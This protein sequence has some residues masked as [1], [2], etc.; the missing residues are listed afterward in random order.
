MN[1]TGEIA[2]LSAAFIWAFNGL[3]VERKTKNIPPLVLNFIRLSIALILVTIITLFDNGSIIEPNITARQWFWMLLSGVLGFTMGDTFLFKSFHTIGARL[4]TLIY[5][6]YPVVV[7]LI[8]FLLFG[9]TL[10]SFNIL[11]IVLVIGGILLVVNKKPKDSGD[12]SAY[13]IT[14]KT[15]LPVSIAILGQSLGLV[16][17]K[18]AL[19]TLTP[20]AGT[21]IRLIGGLFGITA[22]FA[23]QNKWNKLNVIRGDRASC[24]AIAYVGVF[25]TFLAGL[26]S[27]IAI[28]F[29]PAAVASAL[30]STTPVLVLPASWI[31]TRQKI[32][33]VE[34][35]GAILALS[36]ITLLI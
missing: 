15:L 14:L 35:I 27:M 21:Q 10:T 23:I 12:Y 16:T 22:I 3:I 6:F 9:E 18:Y 32:Y 20:M 4:S 7:A 8:S 31:T 28:K 13:R 30:M 19:E 33:P 36:G 24:I 1:H 29:A 34:I 26:L 5:N 17:S 2:A 25:A 11:G